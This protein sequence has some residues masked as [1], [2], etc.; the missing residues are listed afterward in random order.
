[1][2]NIIFLGSKKETQT[3]K[4][5]HSST[6]ND[7]ISYELEIKSKQRW[8]WPLIYEEYVSKAMT[9]EICNKMSS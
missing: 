5:A 6:L 7:S 4:V 1:M 9:L 8:W 3:L 2:V